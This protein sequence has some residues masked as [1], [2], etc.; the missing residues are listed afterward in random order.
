MIYILWFIGLFLASV[1][2]LFAAFTVIV[3]LQEWLEE[4]PKWVRI[5]TIAHWWPI[6]LKGV[7]YDVRFQYT[8]ASVMFLEWPPK[9]ERMLTWRLQRHKRAWYAVSGWRYTLA[10]R[11]CRPIE[12]IDP[13]HCS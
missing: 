1:I 4:K 3:F 11:I 7:L 9:G 8:W 12:K 2:G 10:K 5:I 6:I 13:G